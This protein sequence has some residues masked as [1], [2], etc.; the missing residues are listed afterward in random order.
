MNIRLY[1]FKPEDWIKVCAHIKI[2]GTKE[3]PGEGSEY[4]EELVI[5]CRFCRKTFSF[6]V[7][8][9]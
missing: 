7:L 2:K 5:T 1:H 3:E 9:N 8:V 6:N 4:E